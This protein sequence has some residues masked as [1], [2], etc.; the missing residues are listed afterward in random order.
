[1]KRYVPFV[2]I[3]AVA[4]L[5]VVGGALS[6]KAKLRSAAKRSEDKAAMARLDAGPSAQP[7][8]PVKLDEFADFQCSSCA[9]LAAI[10]FQLERTYGSRIQV[11]FWYFPLPIHRH[12]REAAFAAQ[13]ASLQGHFSEMHDWLFQ[14]QANWSKAADVRP[15]FDSYA[16]EIGLDLAQF[17]HDFESKQVADRITADQER[18]I[19][20]GVE[21]T[22]TLFIDGREFSP[23][24][25]LARVR[26]A[27]EA[28]MV[29]SKTAHSD[30]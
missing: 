24:F 3:L 10:I 17:R 20:L 4:L 23:P 12:A 19:A 30:H 1:M 2:I 7:G 15:L 26:D 25:T 18:G 9:M 16:K 29:P 28:A 11:T 8:D 27:I 5:T 6:Y 14:N 13:A 21:N 22:P